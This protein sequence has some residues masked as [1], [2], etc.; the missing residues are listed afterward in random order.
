[1]GEGAS[2]IGIIGIRHGSGLNQEDF[3]VGGKNS[4]ALDVGSPPG[5][6]AKKVQEISE[7]KIIITYIEG[8]VALEHAVVNLHIGIIS[9]NS[10][11]LE[12]ACSAPG[13]GEN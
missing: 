10:S 8:S 13:H 12:V 6:G 4:P 11:T 7:N 3:G 1:V 9:I 2:T 5:I